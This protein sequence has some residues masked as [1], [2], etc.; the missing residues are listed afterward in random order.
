MGYQGI[1]TNSKR[2]NCRLFIKLFLML[3]VLMP[4]LVFARDI[5]VTTGGNDAAEGSLDHP[6]A[7][8]HRAQLLARQSHTPGEAVHVILHAGTYYLPET[9]SLT[10]EDSG[11]KDSPTIWEAQPN[12]TVVISGGTVLKNLVWTSYKD[13]ILQSK[14]P[15]DLQTDQLF[16]NGDRQILA[17]Y[18]NY[19]PNITIF[20]GYAA[21][22][23]SPE[24]VARWADPTGG[25]FH[26]MHP[27]LWGDFSYLITGKDDKGNLKMEG[28]WQGNRAAKPNVK[29]R[30]VENIFEE[31]DSPGEWFLNS[32]THVLYLYPPVG[33]DLS[34]ATI[35]VPRMK[36]LIEFQGSEKSPVKWVDFSG[37]TFRHTLRTFMET[38]EPLLRT[39]W[40]I[41]RGGA[42]FF[43]GSEDCSL[44]NCYIDQVG[45][46]AVFVNNY[47]RRVKISECRIDKAGATGVMFC[48]DP[49]AVRNPLFE[50]NKRQSL[51]Q[52]DTTPGP[53]TNNYPAD[54]LVDNCLI[55][56]IGRFEKQ[57]TGVGID[58]ASRI[59]VSHCSIY[60]TPRAGIN[61]GD[62][63]WGGHIIEF[64]D[65]FDTVKETGDHGSFNSWGRDRYWGLKGVDLNNITKTA[66]RDLPLA[67][68]IEP[69]TLRNSRWRCDHGWDIDL[70]D[71]SSNYHIYNNL[72][73]HG[74]IKNREGFDRTVENNI[75]VGNSFHSHVWFG[76]SDDV[77][78]H[79]IV[80]EPYKPVGMP[81]IWGKEID[82]NLLQK[83]KATAAAPANELQMIS[84]QDQHSVKA[85]AM[86]VDPEHGD[87]T[88]KPDSPALSL[89]FKN[90][91]MDQFGVQ[92]PALKAI[93]R[94]PSFAIT[95]ETASTRS[96][97]I[98][99]WMGAKIRNIVGMGEMSAHGL[100]GETGV[101]VL[102]LSPDS[103]LGKA[104]LQKN[105]VILGVNRKKIDSINDLPAN[106]VTSL[107]VSR[108]QNV[109]AITVPTR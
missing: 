40:T 96:R 98:Q 1:F 103:P 77:F 102:D 8:L 105:D 18:P 41:H 63:C 48:G 104:G 88:V 59:T 65:V 74:G 4:A 11:T 25:F 107:S 52:I 34:K 20:N 15:D 91:P 72:C 94:T 108:D 37:I 70:D 75:C 66:N 86:F 100:P 58:M 67:D 101:L 12:E 30:F 7:T 23:I 44:Q 21:D 17:R 47:N 79:N 95:Q 64:C 84:K 93:A 16:I 43:N 92:T 73:L 54:C 5:H 78:S 97:K 19:D 90:F 61:I 13:G 82:Y 26:A 85:D 45:G 9:L 109:I 31:L 62:G 68:V 38:K 33:M 69:I 36:N 56:L 39:D 81:A 71:G 87:Y 28:G 32:K 42:I 49:G 29:Y 51:D 14:V 60:D 46:N 99:Q 50:Y 2:M 6:V 22:C 83:S 10:A 55:T 106:S 53:N 24:R 76:N 89:G 35:E 80:F 3:W 27:S 57:A